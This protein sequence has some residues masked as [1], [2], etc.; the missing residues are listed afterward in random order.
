M[1]NS[2]D[3]LKPGAGFVDVALSRPL[4][5]GGAKV[6]SLRLREP[7]AGDIETAQDYSGS[8]ASREITLFANLCEIT[9]DEVRKLP[10]RDYARLQAGYATFT[11]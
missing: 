4:D 2:P 11:N 7:L 1:A 3:Y 6:G 9:P 5:V 8:D 10:L